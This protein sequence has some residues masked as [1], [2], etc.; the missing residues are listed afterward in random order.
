M[1]GHRLNTFISLG[2]NRQRESLKLSVK[3]GIT[4]K[5]GKRKGHGKL[6]EMG[7][8]RKVERK[9]KKKKNNLSPEDH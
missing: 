1:L 4:N 5:R 3:K 9:E 2:T 8:E 7:P 6:R